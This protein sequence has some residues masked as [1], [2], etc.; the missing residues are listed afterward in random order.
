M[1]S[2]PLDI[3]VSS[4]ASGVVA[5]AKM[6]NNTFNTVWSTFPLTESTISIETTNQ[7]QLYATQSSGVSALT[8]NASGSIVAPG[9]SYN[10]SS[11]LEISDDGRSASPGVITVTNY[12]GHSINL[13]LQSPINEASSADSP[14]KNIWMTESMIP[15]NKKCDITPSNTMAVWL[16]PPHTPEDSILPG[17]LGNFITVRYDDTSLQTLQF[18]GDNTA[19]IFA[20]PR[21]IWMSAVK[22]Q[23]RLN[24]SSSKADEKFTKKI[25]QKPVV[26]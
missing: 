17:N 20:E 22:S 18:V 3:K 2:F 11:S 15:K 12:S 23:T 24:D 8:V 7:Y 6:V 16:A 13:V 26:S 25:V 19:G 1:F 4:A 10:V 21:G 14:M 9:K 5:T